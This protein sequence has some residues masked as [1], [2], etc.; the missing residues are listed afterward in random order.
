MTHLGKQAP[1][2]FQACCTGEHMDVQFDMYRIN[3]K[4]QEEKYFTIKLQNAIV[5]DSREFYPETFREENKPYRHMQEI[6]FTYE[7]IIWTD[8]VN[9]IEAEDDWRKPRTS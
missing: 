8:N 5:V 7:K 1:K 9:G 6:K 3:E 4:G 2:V